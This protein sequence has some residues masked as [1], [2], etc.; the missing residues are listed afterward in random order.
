MNNK[1]S[2]QYSEIFENKIKK[3]NGSLDSKL[4]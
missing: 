1:Y 4:N 3:N 2:N